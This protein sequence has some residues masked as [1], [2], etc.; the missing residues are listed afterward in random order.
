MGKEEYNY[1]DIMYM[2]MRYVLHKSSENIDSAKGTLND[3]MRE[4]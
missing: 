4:A 1:A 3:K 2:A